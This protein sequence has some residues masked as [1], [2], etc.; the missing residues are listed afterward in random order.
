MWAYYFCF[1][2]LLTQSTSHQPTPSL[3]KNC[4]PY[5]SPLF[6]KTKTKLLNFLMF[7]SHNKINYGNLPVL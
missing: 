7:V 5:P 3:F 1:S 6:S 4:Q 2:Q